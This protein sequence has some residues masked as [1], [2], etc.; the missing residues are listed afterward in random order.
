MSTPPSPPGSGCPAIRRWV[1]AR[2]WTAP[3]WVYHG[4]LAIAEA[5]IAP[6]LVDSGEVAEQASRLADQVDLFTGRRRTISRRIERHWAMSSD[7]A[8]L[9]RLHWQLDSQPSPIVA[10]RETLDRIARQ[11]P[12]DDR[13]WLGRAD[14]AKSSWSL[15]RS[16]RAIDKVRLQKARRPGR[17][18]GPAELGPRGGSPRRC[19]TR[20]V[21]PPRVP[22]LDR[23]EST[24]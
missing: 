10:M 17:L 3:G 23:P 14:L 8:G 2:S 11:A 12:E 5:S 15:R 22:L 1:P 16:G 13:V 9:L 4:R 19:R 7:Q 20:R 21:S 18:T 6:L 24:R